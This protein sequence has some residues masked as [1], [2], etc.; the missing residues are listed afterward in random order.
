MPGLGTTI[1]TEPTQ[2]QQPI[3][4]VGLLQQQVTDLTL[5]LKTPQITTPERPVPPKPIKI[6]PPI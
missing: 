5:E 4:K 3:Q 6:I 2:I 1:I